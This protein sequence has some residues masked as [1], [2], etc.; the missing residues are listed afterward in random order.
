MRSVPTSSCSSV[1]CRRSAG[2]PLATVARRTSVIGG[3][4]R[5]C[6]MDGVLEHSP[7]M[8]TMLDAGADLSDVQIARH[9]DP[10]TTMR[11]DRTRNTLDRHPNHILATYMASGTYLTCGWVGRLDTRRGQHRSQRLSTQRNACGGARG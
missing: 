10:H 1:G 5:T 3:F 7:Y 11:Y 8:T 2:S 6:V 9:A 4:H